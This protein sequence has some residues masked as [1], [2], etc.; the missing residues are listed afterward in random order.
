MRLVR[1]VRSERGSIVGIHTALTYASDRTIV[2][3]W[4]MPF[5][6]GALLRHMLDVPSSP[7][8]VIPL[9]PRGPEPFCAVYDRRLLASID[10]MVGRGELRAQE[11]VERIQHPVTISERDVAQFG[12]PSRLFFNVNTADDLARA[13]AMARE[14]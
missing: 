3:A 13:E 1:D 12:E 4:D 2:V 6:S 11:I 5:V 8:A 14:E 9:G 7:M 10:T